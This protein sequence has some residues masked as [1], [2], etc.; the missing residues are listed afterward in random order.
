[1]Q[2]PVVLLFLLLHFTGY[3]QSGNPYITN[4]NLSEATI[5]NQVW[6][7]AQNGEG[8]MLFANRRGVL[9]YDGSEWNY[10]A[11]DGFPYAI[12]EEPQT[13]L[14]LIGCDESFGYLEKDLV[15]SYHY[16]SMSDS[17]SDVGEISQIELTPEHMYFYSS[18]SITRIAINDHSDVHQWR[19]NVS[20][21]F[22]GLINYKGK[23]YVNVTKLGLHELT[24]NL[25]KPIS[26]GDVLATSEVL[27]N[28]PFNIGQTLV[29]TSNNTLFLFNGTAFTPYA[30]KD[31][32]YLQESVL[33]GG[34]SLNDDEFAI[35]TLTGGCM[36]VNKFTGKTTYTVNYQTGLPDDEIYAMGIDVNRG[37]WVSHE[38][39]ISR[40]AHTLPVKSFNSYP[41]LEGNLI[42]VMDFDSTVY[43][44]TSEGVF[45]LQK[46]ENFEEIKVLIKNKPVPEEETII[47]E[48]ETIPVEE[49]STTAVPV[50][51]KKEQRKEKR[52]QRKEERK[53]KKEEKRRDKQNKDEPK[54]EA[55]IVETPPEVT[56]SSTTISVPESV[57]AVAPVAEYAYKK[58]YALQSISHVF[59]KVEGL[60]EKCRQLVKYNN[61]LLVAANTGLY[62]IQN[63]EATPIKKGRYINYIAQQHETSRFFIGA[64]DGVFSVVF[65]GTSWDTEE[66]FDDFGENI[67]SIAEEEPQRLWLGGENVAYLIQLDRQAHPITITPYY[68][69]ND[70][71]ERILVRRIFELPFFFLSSGIYSYDSNNDSIQY[72]ENANANFPINSKYIFSQEEITWVFDGREWTSMTNTAQSHAFN[73]KYL[74][75]IDDVQHIYV[76]E[77][78]NVWVIGNNTLHKIEQRDIVDREEAFSVFIKEIASGDTTFTREELLTLHYDNNSLEFRIMAPYYIK[79]DGTEY[80]YLLEGLSQSNWS[81]WS[82]NSTISFPFLPPGNYQLHVRAKNILGQVTEDEVIA[83]NIEAPFWKSRW[84]YLLYALGGI[85]LLY[86]VIKVRERNLQRQRRLLE[87]KVLLRTQ[88]LEEERKKSEALLLNILPAETAEEL[89]TKGKATAKQYNLTTVLFTD[90]KGFT[91]IA[92]AIKPSELVKELDACFVKFD[93]IVERYRIEKIKTIGDAYM[94]AGGIPKPDQN[95]PILVTLAALEICAF[96]DSIAAEKRQQNID[97]WQLRLGIHTGPIIAGVVGKNKF[98]YDIWGDTVNTA[99]RMESSGEPGKVNVS[100]FTYE[101]IKPYFEC[102]HRGK[103]EA[104]DKGKVDMYFVERIKEKYAADAAGT[105]PNELLKDMLELT[106]GMTN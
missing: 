3:G 31:S 68:F 46:T 88:Q 34:I 63:H 21:P 37:L 89:K 54:E 78:K 45:Y 106:D 49:E 92:E 53:R 91:K 24:D 38:F 40:I 18:Q 57:V 20:E 1:M 70:F 15:G 10:I 87:D 39:G 19:H 33:S 76:D 42:A 97:Y 96:V 50:K 66:Y 13:G 52:Q 5:D 59:K 2:L 7:I 17:L 99:A 102:S 28:I 69:D 51:S 94:C 93:E 74:E 41:G 62:E 104:K 67:Y 95:N 25:L 90:F 56:D 6:A 100:G 61:R 32:T 26:N 9:T 35:A 64:A 44:S 47:P 30:L 98:A 85:V 86:L 16:H 8:I 75:L 73:E 22:T 101:L 48:E 72:N 81:K 55:P 71:S 27:F 60:D 43:V 29:G 103:V 4:Y 82:S 65:N 12:V 79:S 77:W 80:Q 83:F 36:L 58:I 105:E 11:T 84:I 23:L 14:I